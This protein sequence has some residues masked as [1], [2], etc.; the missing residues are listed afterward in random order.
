MHAPRNINT[1]L[2]PGIR[3]ILSIQGNILSGATFF[4]A[5]QLIA[6]RSVIRTI[7]WTIDATQTIA[8]RVGLRVAFGNTISPVEADFSTGGLLIG[9][10]APEGSV[11]SLAAVAPGGATDMAVNLSLPDHTGRLLF[12]LS[13]PHLFTVRFLIRTILDGLGRLGPEHGSG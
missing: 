3:R 4:G 10:D 12:R 8:G 6:S 1:D 13:N 7:R 5:S 11:G 9:G 2:I